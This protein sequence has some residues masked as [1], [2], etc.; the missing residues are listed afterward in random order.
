MSRGFTLV[1][2]LTVV[3]I[4]L[5][6]S[7]LVIGVTSF[8]QRKA[9]VDKAR[10]QLRQF[11]LKI[12]DYKRD[13]GGLLPATTGEDVEARSGLIIYRMLY[14]D[15]IGADGVVGTEDDGALDGRPDA[16]AT[17]YLEDLDPNNN[18]Q[19]MIDTKGGNVPVEVVDPWG[20]P[21]RFRNQKGDPDQ[22][23]PDFDLWSH[24]PDGK[25][26]TADDI[27]NW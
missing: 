22:E 15:G 13:A 4:I 20:N 14:G 18:R 19:Q 21:W 12:E 5:I 9:A 7:G 1:E 16:G 8:V 26:G 11:E 2:L 24:G 27:K 6:L 17:V 23:N 3:T 25:N 10:V